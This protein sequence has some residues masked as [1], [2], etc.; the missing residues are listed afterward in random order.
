MEEAGKYF[1]GAGE[2]RR[3]GTVA[4]P[5]QY[6]PC[7]QEEHPAAVSQAGPQYMPGVAVQGGQKEAFISE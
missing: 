1:P 5:T 2:V 3:V 7:G 4:P 6:S